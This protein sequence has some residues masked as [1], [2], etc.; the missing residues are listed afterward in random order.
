MNRI[1]IEFR[2]Y[3]KIVQGLIVYGLIVIGFYFLGAFAHIIYNLF[4]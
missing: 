4:W 3:P 1:L 2:G